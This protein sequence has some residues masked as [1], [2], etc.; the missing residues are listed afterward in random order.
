MEKSEVQRAIEAAR[1]TASA[2]GLSASDGVVVHN[3]NR[4]AVRLTPCNV[5][6]RVAPLAHQ[7]GAEFEVEVGRR[8]AEASC[9][10]EQPEPRV[11]PRVYVHDGFAITLW[12]YYE[13]GPSQDVTPAEFAQT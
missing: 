7:A 1:S 3:S 8:L 5:L 12:T 11:E 13:A 4:I 10:V 6:A 2:L 9:P